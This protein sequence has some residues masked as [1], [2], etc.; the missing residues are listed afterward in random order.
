MAC[1]C[2]G[3]CN[4]GLLRQFQMEAK[5]LERVRAHER[6]QRGGRAYR[7]ILKTR[8]DTFWSGPPPSLALLRTTIP[9]AGSASASGPRAAVKTSGAAARS[10]IYVPTG[11]D[12]WGINDRLALGPSEAMGPVFSRLSLLWHASRLWP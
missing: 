12:F 2:G 8:P 3:I 5:A 7:W 6:Q 1:N 11:L 9:V 4:Q 10:I